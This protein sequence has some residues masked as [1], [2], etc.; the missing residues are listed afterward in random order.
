[1]P[2]AYSGPAPLS[3]LPAAGANPT[4]GRLNLCATYH[5]PV[6]EI[7]VQTEFSAAHAILIAGQREPLHGHNWLVTVTLAGPRLGPDGLLCDFHLVETALR[8][9]AARFHNRALN[10]L[11]P[12]SGHL[13]PTAE[14][15]ARYIADE[16][17]RALNGRL[18]EGVRLASVR[19]TEAPGCAATY[20]PQNP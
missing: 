4:P 20:R 9:L 12:F 10:D 19:V 7:S 18:P 14:N 17:S 6:F 13:N 1:M 8:E 15:V 3:A 2:P 11:P 5:F 16:L